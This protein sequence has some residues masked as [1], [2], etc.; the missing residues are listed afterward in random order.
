MRDR[1]ACERRVYRL[2]ALLSGNLN[3][4]AEVIKAVLDAQPNLQELDSA[5]MDRL[6]VLRSREIAPGSIVSDHVPMKLADALAKMPTQQREAWVF[7]RIYK[8]PMREAARAMDCSVTAMTQHM[9]LANEAMAT[10]LGD[11]G[12]DAADRAAAIFRTWSMSIDVPEFV[13]REEARRRRVRLLLLAIGAVLLVA[14]VV[15]IIALVQSW[16]PA[17]EAG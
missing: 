15:G 7:V 12:E 17:A 2:A 5:R 10:A 16:T 6:T 4:A 9:S 3:A 14:A 11:E 8:I 1:E 13:R